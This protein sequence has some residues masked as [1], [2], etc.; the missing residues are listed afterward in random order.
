MTKGIQGVLCGMLVAA[1]LII[2]FVFPIG[3]LFL[4]EY[5]G[6]RF[7]GIV[8]FI[9]GIIIDGGLVGWIVAKRM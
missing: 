1:V 3:G 8:G 6:D 7:G 2:L 5:M 4:G 9:L